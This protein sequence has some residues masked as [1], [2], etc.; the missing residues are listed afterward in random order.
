MKQPR[1]QWTDFR[2]ILYF[3][4]FVLRKPVERYRV[5]LKLYKITDTLPEDLRVC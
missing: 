2:E 4:E 3:G 1:S 5:W